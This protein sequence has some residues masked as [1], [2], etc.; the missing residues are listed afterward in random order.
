[1]IQKQIL[2]LIVSTVF[3]VFLHSSCGGSLRFVKND[4]NQQYMDQVYPDAWLGFYQMSEFHFEQIRKGVHESLVED[5]SVPEAEQKK[6]IKRFE[7]FKYKENQIFYFYI[8][9]QQPFLKKDLNFNFRIY[10][11]KKRNLIEDVFFTSVKEVHY[12]T[13]VVGGNTIYRYY[14]LVKTKVPIVDENII[15]DRRPVSIEIAFPNGEK[16]HYSMLKVP[17]K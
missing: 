10:D 17:K 2:V 7:A 4:V 5:R 3:A 6:I 11:A 14:W 13:Y 12:G 9:R 16:W 8:W 15:E 1:M